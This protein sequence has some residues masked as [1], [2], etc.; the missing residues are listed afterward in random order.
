MP[1]NYCKDDVEGYINNQL[2]NM[3]FNEETNCINNNT[4]S[5]TTNDNSSIQ[6]SNFYSPFL[7][8]IDINKVKYQEP[9]DIYNN[10]IRFDLNYRNE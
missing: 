9:N 8:E 1:I 4:I 2:P 10:R 5:N 3:R 6:S 7:N